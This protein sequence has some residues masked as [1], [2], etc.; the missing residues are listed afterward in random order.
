MGAAQLAWMQEELAGAAGTGERVL[1]FSHLLV[2][3]ETSSNGSGRTLLWNY[4]GGGFSLA[5]SR[6]LTL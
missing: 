6:P 5:H 1:L 4:D 3:P 2:H